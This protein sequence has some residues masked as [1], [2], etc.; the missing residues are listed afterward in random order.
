MMAK[1]ARKAKTYDY[2]GFKVTIDDNL[3]NAF[4]SMFDDIENKVLRPAAY[5]AATVLYDEVKLRV[6]EKT[7][8]LKNAIYRWRER[9][10]V[11]KKSIFYVG[12]NKK[13]APHWSLIEHGHIQRHAQ[14]LIDG[15]W[16]TLE[17][18]PLSSPKHIAA[19][20]YFRPA[21][22]AKIQEAINTGL[23]V[24]SKK[25]SEQND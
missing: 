8:K 15:E 18:Q 4:N 16:K 5:A 20:P 13:Q 11:E 19:R 2:E 24:L 12:V 22:D 14:V 1:H 10:P 23:D 7:G 3:Q 6:P 21:F 9:N 25:L 17:N